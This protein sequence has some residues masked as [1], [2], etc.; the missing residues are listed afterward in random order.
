MRIAPSCLHLWSNDAAPEGGADGATSVCSAVVSP[1]DPLPPFVSASI[2]GVVSG[3]AILS[4]YERRTLTPRVLSVDLSDA[5][6]PAIT[7]E[8]PLTTGPATVIQTQ[9]VQSGTTAAVYT[10]LPGVPATTGAPAVSGRLIGVDASGGSLALRS[11]VPMPPSAFV[12]AAAPGVLLFGAMDDTGSDA[13]LVAFDMS[14]STGAV[15]TGDTET[16]TA[17]RAVEG[18]DIRNGVARVLVTTLT[19]VTDQQTLLTYDVRDPRN[20]TSR[21]YFG[22]ARISRVCGRPPTALRNICRRRS[23]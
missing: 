1:G 23:K 11:E 22:S 9:W 20:P 15:V 17:G 5:T 14:S 18:L 19:N 16:V 10:A 8:V 12:I 3:H 6:H 13:R 21:P 2:H 4:T 7:A